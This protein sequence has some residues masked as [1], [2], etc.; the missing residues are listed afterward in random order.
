MSYNV[1]LLTHLADAVEKWGPLWSHSA[2]VFEDVIG[3][4]KTVYHG[5]QLVP[6]HILKY[7]SA[8][9]SVIHLWT[10]TEASGEVLDLFDDL[11]CG[12]RSVS[13]ATKVGA[14]F[15][16]LARHAVRMLNVSELVALHNNLAVS[17]SAETTYM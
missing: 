12:R 13:C 9:K 8:W 17:I 2:F 6:K 7:F 15:V 10:M 16:G 14:S 3:L 1:H 11:S 5:T 4:L